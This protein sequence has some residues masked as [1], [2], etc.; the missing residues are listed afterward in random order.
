MEATEAEIDAYVAKH[1]ELDP[2]KA[3]EQAE[4]LYKRARAGEDF[5]KLAEE[6][7]T[8]PGSKSKGGDLGWFGRGQMVKP[9]EDV[10]FALQ[11]GQISD[12]VES[13]FG[14]HI[15]KVEERGKRP[16]SNGALEEQVH[17]R[18]IL[19]GGTMQGDPTG[20][21]QSLRERAKKAAD[22]EKQK[23]LIDQIVARS[24]VTVADDFQVT[25][26]QPGTSPSTMRT[27]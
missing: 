16:G 22:E 17:A 2:T 5:G 14:Y 11:P 21:P 27:P 23:G 13:T 25:P 15:I 4:E 10:A 3:R 19:I 18:H 6:Y 1:P 12:V 26:T 7:S 24:N 8:D 9:F 20:K